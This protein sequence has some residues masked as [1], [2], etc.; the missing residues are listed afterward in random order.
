MHTKI[1]AALVASMTLACGAYAI[2]QVHSAPPP[3]SMRLQLTYS[4]AGNGTV[5]ASEQLMDTSGLGSDFCMPNFDATLKN[6]TLA[7]AKEK[8]PRMVEDRLNSTIACL[9]AVKEE[10]SQIPRP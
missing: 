2:A 4:D 10:F 8:L 3:S 7:D 6:V 9:T 5:N 1:S